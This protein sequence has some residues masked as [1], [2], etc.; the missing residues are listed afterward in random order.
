[1]SWERLHLHGGEVDRAFAVAAEATAPNARWYS[2]LAALQVEIAA[3][4]GA[5]GIPRLAAEVRKGFDRQPWAEAMLI[6][7]EARFSGRPESWL[8]AADAF[9]SIAARFEW[10][11]TLVLADGLNGRDGADIL[12]ALG[13]QPPWRDPSSSALQRASGA[14]P[15]SEESP[16]SSN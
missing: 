10:A 1:M 14:Q 4:Q 2:Y 9:A 11:C 16:G 5:P 12:T 8:Q 3:A 15:G 6:R 13:C 7:A